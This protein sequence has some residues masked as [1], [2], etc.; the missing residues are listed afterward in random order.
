MDR[1]EGE[2]EK[3]L[4]LRAKKGFLVMAPLFDEGRRNRPG[5]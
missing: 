1:F 3:L 4:E 5:E 2:V